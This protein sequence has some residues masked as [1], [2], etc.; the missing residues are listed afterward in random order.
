LASVLRLHARLR[1][2]APFL[3]YER[4]P[5]VVETRSW[6]QQLERAARAAGALARLGVAP[7]ER[8]H[9]AL[10]N[11]PEFYDAWFGA[12]LLGVAIVPTNPLATAEE[13][14]FVLADCQARTSITQVDLAE[15]V[16]A[17]G[18]TVHCVEDGVLA[19]ADPE[20][21]VP[22][23][24]PSDTLGVLYTSGTTSR[25]KG[26]LVTHAAYLC[27]GDAVA[28]HMRLRPDDRNLVVLP[29]FHGNAQYYSSMSALVT[30][31]AVALA[32]RFSA[33]RWS[34]QARTMR[35]TTASLFAAPIRM[36]LAAGPSEH[37]TAHALRVVLFA[38]NVTP[39]QCSEFETRFGVPL[40]QLWGMTE[41]VTP[42]LMNPLY[43]ERRNMTMGRPVSAVSVRVRAD[44]GADAATGEPGELLVHGQPGRT[45]MSGYLDNPE[46]TAEALR[47][48][49][50]GDGVWL[51]TGDTVCADAEGYLAFVDRR[52]DMIKRAGENVASGEIER[53]VNEHRAV[54]DSAAVG[55]PDEMRDE[56]VHLVVVLHD[57][58]Q[59]DADELRAWCAQRLAKFKIPDTV[60]FVDALPRTSVGKIQKHLLR[61]PAP[62]PSEQ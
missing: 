23:P 59:V 34:E 27:A 35:A 49:D 26:V 45:I 1:G 9:L 62:A 60:E 2:D 39:G 40:V 30:G 32:P 42:S 46:A 29:L 17:A 5:G 18:G 11:R 28:G 33:G 37:D 21:D 41:T 8:V 55:V 20:T 12:A 31:A 14:S 52:K 10:T 22:A 44:D 36:I 50:D 47:P 54:F 48:A 15:T 43:G 58:A 38:Q 13:L 56:A 57:G 6:A 7:G 19:E 16:A 3:L 4:E 61:R 51:H 53:V 25:P 24:R